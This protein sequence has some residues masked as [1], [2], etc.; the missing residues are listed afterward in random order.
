M[1]SP[2]VGRTAAVG[3][4]PVCAPATHTVRELTALVGLL[5]AERPGLTSV[6]V[7]HSRDTAS[8]AAARAF[9]C[10]WEARGGTILTVADW[11][12]EAASWL[13]PARRLTAQ[14]PDAWV[15][16]AGLIGYAQLARRLC[17]EGSWDPARTFG[18]ASLADS[19]LPALTGRGV[20][21]GMRGAAA[22]G[23]T[24]RFEREWLVRTDG[25]AQR[26]PKQ[27]GPGHKQP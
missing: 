27:I 25:P 5:T 8:V 1:T 7:G 24:W 18:F 23:G 12:E 20:L 9:A 21:H 2:L 6:A 26:P 15:I 3:L 10:A 13:R 16:A 17:R 14:T 19:R 4:G 11:P 22:D